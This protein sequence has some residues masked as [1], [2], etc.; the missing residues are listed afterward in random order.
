MIPIIFPDMSR[1]HLLFSWFPLACSDPSRDGVLLLMNLIG[2]SF[3]SHDRVNF[4]RFPLAVDF[5][6][7]ETGLGLLCIR[8][9]GNK[10]SLCLHPTGNLIS[11]PIHR[12]HA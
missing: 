5:S 11:Y 12:L 10:Y 3:E 8:F 9:P 7:E 1:G 4:P 2:C 6:I